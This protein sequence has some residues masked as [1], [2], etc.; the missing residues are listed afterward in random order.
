MSRRRIAIPLEVTAISAEILPVIRH[1]FEPDQVELTLLAVAERGL[2]PAA[3]EVYF[4]DLPPTLYTVPVYS[5]E[6]WQEYC[7]DLQAKL[8]L[9]ATPLAEAGYQV[10]T[11]L[12]QGNKV[13]AIAEYVEQSRFDLVAMATYGRKGLNRLIYGSVAERLLRMVSVPLLLVRHQP[14]TD[15]TG[16]PVKHLDWRPAKPLLA[17]AV[18]HRSAHAVQPV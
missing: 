13:P 7:A 9:A 10:Q 5:E 17:A 3:T 4:T 18:E 16:T 15:E 12:L 8:T 1:L 2:S 11:V 14:E 6:E